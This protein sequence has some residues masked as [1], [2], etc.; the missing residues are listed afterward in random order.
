[1]EV[2]KPSRH[3][4]NGRWRGRRNIFLVA[5]TG[6]F[7]GAVCED[8]KVRMWTLPEGKL[9]REIDLGN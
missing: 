5:Q 4:D 3:T 6:K 1:L 7:C 8:H 9:V 2:T